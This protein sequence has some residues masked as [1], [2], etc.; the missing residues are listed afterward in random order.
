MM[1]HMCYIIMEQTMQSQRLLFCHWQILFIQI[2]VVP[3]SHSYISEHTKCEFQNILGVQMV[4][5][6]ISGKRYSEDILVGWTGWFQ[7]TFAT[8]GQLNCY[9]QT[10]GTNGISSIHSIF[11]E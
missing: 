10:Q 11:F 1:L 9:M 2:V 6:Q 7:Q 8:Y 3:I 4:Y 5:V